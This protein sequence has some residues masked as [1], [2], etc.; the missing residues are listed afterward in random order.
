MGHFYKLGPCAYVF[1]RREKLKNVVDIPKRLEGY[2]KEY[3]RILSKNLVDFVDLK[4]LKI[5][6]KKRVEFKK[7]QID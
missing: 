4:T 6:S 7:N 3:P 2:S 5:L 1:S